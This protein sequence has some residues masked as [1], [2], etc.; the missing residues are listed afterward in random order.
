MSISGTVSP[1]RQ[2]G[3]FKVSDTVCSA[4]V[5]DVPVT[6]L[7]RE[8]LSQKANE[9]LALDDE[10]S[11]YP[12][13]CR[14]AELTENSPH[15]SIIAGVTAVR[16]ERSDEAAAHF[17]RALD[18]APDNYDAAYNLALVRMSLQDL[19]GALSLLRA[20]ARRHSSNAG[21]QNDLAV[22]WWNKGRPIRAE[23]AFNHAIRLDPNSSQARN[24]AMEFFLSTGR[25]DNAWRFLERHESR[26]ELTELSRSEINQW[27]KILQDNQTINV[28]EDEERVGGPEHRM[29]SIAETDTAVGRIAV[30]ASN[31]TFIEAVTNVLSQHNE[32]KYFSGQSVD[33]MAEL[34]SWA[35]VSWFEWCDQ[36]L[37]HASRL[38]KRCAVVC[39]L[40]SYEAF[41]DMPGKVDWSKIDRLIFVN[42][43]VREI[44]AAQIP[45]W[46]PSGI[47]HNGVNLDRF[48]VPPDKRYGKKIASVG[49]INYKKNPGLLLYCFK[50]I[51]EYDPE[52][53][54]H[55]AGTHQDPRIAVYFE[56]FLRH[57]PLPVSFNGWVQDI[58]AWFED[59]AFV[60]ST[61]FFESFHYSI[62]EG[63]ACGVIPLIHDWR[64]A[65][66]LYPGGYLFSDPD[67]CVSLLRRLERSNRYQLAD[68]NRRY[69]DERFNQ[70]DKVSQIVALLKDV[71]AKCSKSEQG[72]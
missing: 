21:L 34:M 62:A 4:S 23:A 12:Y 72:Y 46:V 67:E 42:E 52:Y 1:D 68:K 3:I 47:I 30:F 48:R 19:D 9:Y 17:T 55:I 15:P 41:T 38:P 35:D 11:A 61:S 51:H 64:G 10:K 18:I 32:V 70:A 36:I 69:I 7:A 31:R 26:G 54:L 24:N 5:T 13:L 20:L 28:Q 39:R 25:L 29:P 71:L 27:K 53:T 58:P 66:E 56:H 8:E 33:E 22:L 44:A 60:I 63:M 6:S 57:N 40:H 59:K 65:R 37:I 16:L 49:Y 2:N 43:S 45:E 14:L 50:K